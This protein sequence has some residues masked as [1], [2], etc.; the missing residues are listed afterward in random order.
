M[1]WFRR[2]PAV[3][4]LPCFTARLF[5]SKHALF[6]LFAFVF[7]QHCPKIL[8]EASFRRVW[9]V[10]QNVLDRD[11][12]AFEFGAT[13]EVERVVGFQEKANVLKSEAPKTAAPGWRETT[14]S[15]TANSWAEVL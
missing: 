15:A 6:D 1:Y 5:A 3:I 7:G 12:G 2:A 9:K 4:T 11:T 10:V 8:V 14:K 13:K